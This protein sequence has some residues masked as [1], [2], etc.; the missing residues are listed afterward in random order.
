MIFLGGLIQST[1]INAHVP[2]GNSPR[3]NELI[4]LILDDNYGTLFRDSLKWTH[5]F[6]IRDRLDDPSIKQFDN[7]LFH[8]LL[9]IRI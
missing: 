4:M 7:L 2:P 5:P 1:I 8:N 6:T 3:K 9:H